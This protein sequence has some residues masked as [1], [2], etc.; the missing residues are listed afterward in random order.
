MK[1][2]ISK[3]VQIVFSIFPCLH[4]TATKTTLKNV[5]AAELLL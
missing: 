2:K 3:V 5:K 4:C 1:S